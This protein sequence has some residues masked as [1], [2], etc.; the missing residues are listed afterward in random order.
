MSQK[1]EW[2]P[3]GIHQTCKKPILLGYK[4]IDGSTK[5]AHGYHP[6]VTHWL[7]APLHFG[8]QISNTFSFG[9]IP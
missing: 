2:V 4:D 7:L 3:I 9:N 5:I 8:I 1:G 6:L